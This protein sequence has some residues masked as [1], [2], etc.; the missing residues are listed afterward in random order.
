MATCPRRFDTSLYPPFW[1]K[2][3]ELIDDALAIDAF[4]FDASDLMPVE[5]GERAFWKGMLTYLD[6]GPGSVDRIL[7]ELEAAWPD[8]G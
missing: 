5:I 2:Q 8:D 4:R 1:R 3:A 7:A 6:E